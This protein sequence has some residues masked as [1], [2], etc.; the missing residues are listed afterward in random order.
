MKTAS[1]HQLAL[2][3]II[4]CLGLA[5]ATAQQA[6]PRWNPTLEQVIVSA[7]VPKNYRVIMTNS[8]LGEAYIVSASMD[9]PYSDLDLA[10]EPD[11]TEF[12]RRIHVAAH[13][14]CQELDLKYPQTQ[15]PILDGFDCEHD[16]AREGMERADLVIASARH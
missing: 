11:A 2:A 13:L 14:V 3:A 16:A 9:V 6:R 5:P 8:R 10:K 1:L 12:G 4:L 15:Y 7:K